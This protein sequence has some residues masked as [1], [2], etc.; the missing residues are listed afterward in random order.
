MSDRC[1]RCNQPLGQHGFHEHDED[2]LRAAIARAETAEVER[3]DLILR[4][5]RALDALTAM[6]STYGRHHRPDLTD[7]EGP[8]DNDYEG[9]SILAFGVLEAEGRIERRENNDTSWYVE[10]TDEDE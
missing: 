9:E 5:G 2:C 1:N 6:V 8:L 4:L 10:V 3:D 7:D